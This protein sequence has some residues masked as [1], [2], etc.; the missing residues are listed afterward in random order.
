M[1][2][3]ASGIGS[4]KSGTEQWI[5]PREAPA[6]AS[7]LQGHRLQFPMWKAADDKGTCIQYFLF[8]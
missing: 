7:N 4:E 2:P 5:S 3:K 1:A 6:N 8:M